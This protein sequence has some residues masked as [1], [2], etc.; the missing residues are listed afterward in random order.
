MSPSLNSP[1][2]AAA[3]IPVASMPRMRGKATPGEAPLRV[4]I[5]DRLRPN[6][7]TRI[8]TQP[9]SGVGMGRSSRMRALGPPGLW[10]TAARIVLGMVWVMVSGRWKGGG[11]EKCWRDREKGFGLMPSRGS[12]LRILLPRKSMYRL[13]DLG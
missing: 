5:S 13:E 12:I 2:G 8:R 6:A 3:T 1:P 10:T 7:L 9:L 11:V 4:N